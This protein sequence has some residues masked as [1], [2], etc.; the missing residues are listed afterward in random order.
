M[1]KHVGGH[2]LIK[3][4]Q[5]TIEHL[6]VLILHSVTPSCMRLLYVF[7]TYYQTAPQL[8]ICLKTYFYVVV[9]TINYEAHPIFGLY[10]TTTLSASP[11]PI[12]KLLSV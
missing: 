10:L 3:Q 8:D 9:L 11:K 7:V 6:L 1:P 2:P 4:Y 12:N 5:N